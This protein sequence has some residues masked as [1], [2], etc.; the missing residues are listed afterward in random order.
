[1]VR[2]GEFVSRVLGGARRSPPPALTFQQM[3]WTALLRHSCFSLRARGNFHHLLSVHSNTQAGPL[4]FPRK[5][6][7]A[8]LNCDF[9]LPV[10]G[11]LLLTRHNAPDCC[12]STPSFLFLSSFRRT[13]K[14]VVFWG[15]RRRLRE[16]AGS[17]SAS[18]L[19]LAFVHLPV[20]IN[21]KRS[22]GQ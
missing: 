3:E 5:N 2:D 14:P 18:K 19:T 9:Y 7:S 6:T 11:L 16:Q 10:C 21:T 13:Q 8:L 15:A 17:R 22:F 12:L 4:L 20:N 1:M